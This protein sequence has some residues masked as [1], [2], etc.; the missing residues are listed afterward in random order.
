MFGAAKGPVQAANFDETWCF[1]LIGGG[2]GRFWGTEPVWTSILDEPGQIGPG[3]RNSASSPYPG[4]PIFRQHPSPEGP[5]PA[6]TYTSLAPDFGPGMRDALLDLLLT[7][8]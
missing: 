5:F 6:E 1:R 3:P 8:L 4:I 2:G 7:T